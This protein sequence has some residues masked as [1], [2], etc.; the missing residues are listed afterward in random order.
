MTEYQWGTV[1]AT[2]RPEPKTKLLR[3]VM[4]M[5]WAFMSVVLLYVCVIVYNLNGTCFYFLVFTRFSC[6]SGAT[7]CHCH[8]VCVTYMH[9]ILPLALFLVCNG[10]KLCGANYFS[11]LLPVNSII[12]HS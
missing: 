8:V 6:N 11:A 3:F 5:L 12:P 2:H 9:Y 4:A 7:L 10:Y 1:L